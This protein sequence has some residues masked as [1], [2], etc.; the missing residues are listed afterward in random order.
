MKAESLIPARLDYLEA[1]GEG[2]TAASYVDLEEHDLPP[3]YLAADGLIEY[4][5]VPNPIG[6]QLPSQTMRRGY[7]DCKDVAA[8]RAAELRQQ[9][10]PARMAIIPSTRHRGSFHAIVRWPDGTLE[11]PSRFIMAIQRGRMS[12]N[13]AYLLIADETEGDDDGE[14]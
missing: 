4:R 2:L 10:I 14:Y 12:P 1:Y 9:G 5:L 8:W 13:E 7:G 3:V 6:W 11:D